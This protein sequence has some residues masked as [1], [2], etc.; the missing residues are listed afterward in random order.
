MRCS[1]CRGI[2]FIRAEQL[3]GPDAL[4]TCPVCRG[5]GIGSPIDMIT[6]TALFWLSVAWALVK[7]AFYRLRYR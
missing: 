6:R 4:I 1:Q 7:V 5:K 2:R 3:I